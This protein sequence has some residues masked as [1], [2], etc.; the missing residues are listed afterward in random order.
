[1]STN[2]IKSIID[3]WIR[4]SE[5]DENQNSFNL[6]S[7]NYAFHSV[8]NLAKKLLKYDKTGTFIVLYLKASF[9]TICK[10]IN[11]KLIEYLSDPTIFKDY[12]EMWNEFESDEIKQIESNIIHN[13]LNTTTQNKT[14]GEADISKEMEL[15]R[16]SIEYIAEELSKCKTE[17]YYLEYGNRIP[18]IKF[19][20]V[21]E[22]GNTTTEVILKIEKSADGL[23]LCYITDFNSC[24]G[25][26]SYILK[27]GNTII[28]V[29]DR[30]D[31]SFVGQHNRSRNNRF[32]EDK[33]WHIFPYDD[34]VNLE[35][36]DY[37]GYAKSL[38]C[39]IDSIDIQKLS[40][41]FKYTVMMTASLIIKR[42]EHTLIDNLVDEDNI[43]LVYIDSMLS[44]NAKLEDTRALIPVD[45]KS[46]VVYNN[47]SLRFD[48][49][50]L[51]I[52]SNMF[53]KTYDYDY[54]HPKRY[55][56]TYTD[57]NQILIETFG[58]GFSIDH[59]SILRRQYPQLTDG[60][61][62][63][64]DTVV[65][66]FIGPKDK[67]EL[68]YYRQCR[69]QLKD[70][71]INK[72]V[73]EYKEFGGYAAVIDW[74]ETAI[75][76]NEENLIQ[77][78]VQFYKDVQEGIEHSCDISNWG[79][80]CG[81]NLSITIL[82]GTDKGRYIPRQNPKFILN[83]QT[84]ESTFRCPITGKNANI[85]FVFQPNTYQ[86]IEKLVNQQVP[87]I[88]KGFKYSGYDGSAGNDLIHSCDPV[89]FIEN[90]FAYHRS[91]EVQKTF[92]C[93]RSEPFNIAI[94]L[95]KLGINRL[96]KEI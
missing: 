2:N 8:G 40:P 86:N 92:P 9:E 20:P 24:G 69:I 5:Y 62:G 90:P 25:Y 22:V 27:S 34:I 41:K 96:L 43:E 49:N 51:N 65:S 18:S 95:S 78:C 29:N 4:I 74:Y 71:I 11:V 88:L 59:D 61:E 66:E 42:F 45:H 15:F 21:I 14:I 75:H 10:D 83:E 73:E 38:K 31:E 28:S 91:F 60:S 37:K 26:F 39:T 19:H 52:K 63:S 6:L 16:D 67:I 58:D 68:E 48:F 1:M 13:I 84:G 17:A 55:C 70:H 80:P 44:N 46:C 7:S 72:M 47:R 64:S 57:A 3:Q 89:G 33:C 93:I 53:Q 82:E 87:K 79:I 23:Y 30:I 35:G 32:I 94:G 81:D 85:W 76:D 77:R 12:L 56:G 54:K 36:S 50:S